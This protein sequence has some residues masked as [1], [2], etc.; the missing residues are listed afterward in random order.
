M[1][2]FTLEPYHELIQTAFDDF[3]GVRERQRG[4]RRNPTDLS[5]RG[6]VTGGK[7]L[8]GFL[9]LLRQV[10]L[11]M[12][13][14]DKCIY[15][16]ANHLPGYFRPTKNWDFLII[17]PAG[18]LVA[19]AELKSQVGSFGNNFNN[20]TEEALGSSVDFWTAFRENV[21]S[22]HLPPWAGYLFIVEKRDKSTT[23][24]KLAQPFFSVMPEFIGSSYIDRYQLFCQRLMLER[25]Y[26]ATS[27]LWT[28]RPDEYGDVSAELSLQTFLFSLMGHLQSRNHE[29]S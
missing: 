16:K 5:N 13:I 23:A 27:L 2:Q 11:D 1:T 17:S 22:G 25:H 6:A 21:Y 28:S 20:R 3:W 10:S 8:D 7:Q 9:E 4:V 26:S 29:F 18:R 12:G 19:L 24:V 14:P 15:L